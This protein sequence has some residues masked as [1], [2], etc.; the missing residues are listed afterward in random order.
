MFAG[1]WMTN[2][3]GVRKFDTDDSFDDREIYAAAEAAKQSLI[4][5]LERWCQWLGSSGAPAAPPI[6]GS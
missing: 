2:A 1:S 4:G 5:G 3:T 6:C